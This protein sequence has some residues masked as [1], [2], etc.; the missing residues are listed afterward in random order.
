[1]IHWRIALGRQPVQ[2]RQKLAF[3]L[4]KFGS[5]KHAL[6]DIETGTPIGVDNRGIE[7]AVGGQSEWPA[8]VERGRLG[9][10]LAEIGLHRGFFG[11]KISVHYI[12]WLLYPS[13]PFGRLD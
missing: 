4:G 7:L 9:L 12:H 13:L 5:V 10:A 3:D 6:E 2:Q 11:T 1:V 8:I